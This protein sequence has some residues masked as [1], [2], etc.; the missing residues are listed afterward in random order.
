M[1]TVK[2]KKGL[3]MMLETKMFKKQ[4]YRKVLKEFDDKL[5]IDY[6]ATIDDTTGDFNLTCEIEEREEI[7][8]IK[9]I[10]DKYEAYEL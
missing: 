1:G 8:I 2:T 10:E 5:G 6:E 9:T 4:D 7:D 3:Q